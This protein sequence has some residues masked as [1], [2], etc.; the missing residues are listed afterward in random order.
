MSV[1]EHV[2]AGPAAG[3]GETICT[4]AL[5]FLTVIACATSASAQ[6]ATNNSDS[7][8]A[9]ATGALG[10]ASGI[11]NVG[12]WTARFTLHF[13]LPDAKVPCLF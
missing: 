9:T 10:H 6:S 5:A 1:H 4:T 13:V 11:T 3:I 7:T 12:N 2:K 8:S